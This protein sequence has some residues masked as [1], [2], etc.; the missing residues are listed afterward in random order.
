MTPTIPDV[1]LPDGAVK[2]SKWQDVHTDK[3]FRFFEGASWE[4]FRRNERRDEIV[5]R[6]IGIQELDGTV[7]REVVVHQTH[8]DDPL[9]PSEAMQLVRALVGAVQEIERWSK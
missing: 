5:V 1:P 2:A 8:A 6:V 9:T 3:A 7:K 4:V